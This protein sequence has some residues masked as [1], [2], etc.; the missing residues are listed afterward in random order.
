M[1]AEII[2][3]LRRK[4]RKRR[5][6]LHEVD[7]L[8][9]FLRA[10]ALVEGVVPVHQ[11]RTQLIE[12]EAAAR[13]GHSTFAL[14]VAVDD[15]AHPLGGDGLGVVHHLHQNELAVP[16]VRLIHVQH[17]VRR[18]AGTGEGVENN[19]IWVGSDLQNAFNKACRFWGVKGRFSTEN[20]KQVFFCLVGVTGFCKR[21]KICGRF[22]SNIFEICLSTN[23]ALTTACEIKP[24]PLPTFHNTH[25]FSVCCI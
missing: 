23:T 12:G 14:A 24:W 4:R 22:P 13:A 6:R 15:P 10:H 25:C 3:F 1:A 9:D 21:P 11:R 8:P 20:G 7:V 2:G 16:A 17:S 18:R 19:G 5:F